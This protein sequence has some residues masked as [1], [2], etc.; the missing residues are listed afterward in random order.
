MAWSDYEIKMGKLVLSQNRD[1]ITVYR[2]ET[3]SSS[4]TLGEPALSAIWEGKFVK[5]T[6]KN[7]VRL[8]SDTSSYSKV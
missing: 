2:S 8:Y 3:S 5:V 6:L 1:R 7:E 4:I